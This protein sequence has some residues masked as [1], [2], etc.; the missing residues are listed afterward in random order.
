M[1]KRENWWVWVTTAL[2]AFGLF[3]CRVAWA[4]VPSEWPRYAIQ[5][6][7]EFG[8][9]AGLLRSICSAESDWKPYLTGIA[10]EIGVCQMKPATLAMFVHDSPENMRDPYYSIYYAGV[11]LDWVSRQLKTRNPDILAAAYNRGPYSEVVRYMQK[12]RSRR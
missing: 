3:G 2:L 8:L 11:Y 5:V 9:P 12:V 1:F 4:E 6:E 10:G 7:G